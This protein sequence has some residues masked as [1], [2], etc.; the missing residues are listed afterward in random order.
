[1]EKEKAELEHRRQTAF[2]EKDRKMGVKPTEVEK[3]KKPAPTM[4][5][6]GFRLAK[7]NGA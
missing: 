3:N 5:F 6:S 7:R 1:L 2:K 4:K